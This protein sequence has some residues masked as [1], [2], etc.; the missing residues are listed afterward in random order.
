MVL[1]FRWVLSSLS[2]TRWLRDKCR[3]QMGGTLQIT[4]LFGGFFRHFPQTRLKDPNL[5]AYSYKKW[6]PPSRTFSESLFSSTFW[7]PNMFDPGNSAGDLFGMVSSRVTP[8]RSGIE[9]VTAGITWTLFIPRCQSHFCLH[10]RTNSASLT[11]K[12]Y[13]HHEK[14]PGKKWT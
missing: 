12:S 7:T 11:L 13:F 5:V 14:T 8:Q 6:H 10:R 1:L 3:E 4:N 2:E 9:K